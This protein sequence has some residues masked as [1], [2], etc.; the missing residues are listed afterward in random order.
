[1]TQHTSLDLPRFAQKGT[2]RSFQLR[3][4]TAADW[5]GQWPTDRTGDILVS[6][7]PG[8]ESGSV[9]VFWLG[10][11]TADC[12]NVKRWI[13]QHLDDHDVVSIYS[14]PALPEDAHSSL[15]GDLAELTAA[16]ASRASGTDFKAEAIAMADAYLNNV[17]L[18]TYTELS[19]ALRWKPIHLAP[20]DRYILGRDPGLKRPFVMIWNVPGQ[21]FEA[22]NG[23]GDEI[24][25]EYMD[26]PQG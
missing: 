16:A 24:P 23:M 6:E 11:K 4:S 10:D 1:M 5:A 15:K 14:V 2:G 22:A 26:L 19:N 8:N 7:C 21:Q 9:F 12:P 25:T 3:P 20:K 17:C 13:E 18:P